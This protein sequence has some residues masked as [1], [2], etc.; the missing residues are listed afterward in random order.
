MSEGTDVPPLAPGP[1]VVLGSVWTDDGCRLRLRRPGN[2]STLVPAV[3]LEL[4]YRISPGGPRHCVGHQS[5]KRNDGRYVECH[6]RPQAGEKTCVSCSVANAELAAD[7]HHAHTRDSGEIH[8]AVLQHLR[9]SNVL[10]LAA[11]REGSIKVGTST[12]TRRQTRLAEQGAWRAVEAVTVADG[13]AVRRLEDLVTERLGLTQAVATSRK[14]KGMV[15]PRDDA[16]LDRRLAE[17]VAEVHRLLETDEGRVAADHAQP[18]AE[19]WTCPGAD[20][21]WWDRPH[22]YPIGLGDGSHHVRIEGMCGRVAALQRPGGTDHFVDDV[23]RLFGRELEIG[24][25]AP[26]DLVVQD[27]LF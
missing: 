1:L 3:G 18:T 24:A 27:S 23:G 22:P 10:Y 5:P 13:I 16:D 8:Q 26:D 11:F 4:N 9:R 20:A 17:H 12:G 14:L 15:N 6:N 2:D 7:L 19:W 21:P 25:F